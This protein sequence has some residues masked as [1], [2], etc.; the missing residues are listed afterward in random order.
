MNEQSVHATPA[1]QLAASSAGTPRN[2]TEEEREKRRERAKRAR[3]AKQAK[4][5]AQVVQGI[6]RAAPVKS[7]PAPA[8]TPTPG[9]HVVPGVKRKIVTPRRIVPVRRSGGFTMRA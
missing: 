1:A 5:A 7:V 6:R 3:E 9:T 2:I 8:P 4:Q